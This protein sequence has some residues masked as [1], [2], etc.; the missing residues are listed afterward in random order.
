MG[1]FAL[2]LQARSESSCRTTWWKGSRRQW[3]DPVLGEMSSLA[4]NWW[5]TYAAAQK[6]IRM[7]PTVERS[8]HGTKSDG[9]PVELFTLTSG[10]GSRLRLSS[11]G[12]TIVSLEVPDRVGKVGDVVLGYEDLR[13][14]EEDGYYLGCVVGRYANRIA[15]GRFT[16]DG[17]EHVLPVNNGP[18]HLHGGPE[19][20]Q[21]KVWRAESF[22]RGDA[23]GVTFRH[24]SPDG[25]AGY[26]GQLEATVTYTLHTDSSIRIE[27]GARTSRPTVVCL[28][29][30]AYF[31]LAGHRQPSVLDH[32]LWLGASKYTPVDETIIPTGELVAVAGTPLDFTTPRRIGDRIDALHEQLRR[33][34]GYDHNWVLDGTWGTLLHAARLFSPESGRVLDVLTT[35]PGIQVYSGNFLGGNLRGKEGANYPKRSAICLETQHFPDS[36]NQP[37]FPST[38]LRPGEELSSTTLLRFS[39]EASMNWPTG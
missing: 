29:Q 21:R 37:G 15:K 6:R 13:G 14:Y 17:K 16:L 24:T 9:T 31:N 19:G 1:V 11:F 30:H 27:Y 38:V 26:P 34:G 35:E 36:P 4:V 18:N 33:A 10:S 22:V 5:L 7:Q 12:A 8:N 20:F 39:A 28:T 3:P 32:W 25:D 2:V 23:V